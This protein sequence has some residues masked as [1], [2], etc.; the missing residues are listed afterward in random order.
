M[1][2]HLLEAIHATVLVRLF[3][4]FWRWILALLAGFHVDESSQ[5]NGVFPS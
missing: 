5:S 1:R 3:F 4:I 2:T